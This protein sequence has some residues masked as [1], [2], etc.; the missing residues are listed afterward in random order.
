[1]DFRVRISSWIVELDFQVRIFEL[2]CRVGFL[3][4]VTSNPAA[5]NRLAEFVGK[6]SRSVLPFLFCDIAKA[7]MKKEARH[8]VLH[9]VIFL[10][11]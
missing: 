10:H 6:P 2:G 9:E 1:M 5:T 7:Y 3:K 8:C 11:Q 4:M